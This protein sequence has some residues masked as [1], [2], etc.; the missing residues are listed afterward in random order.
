[1]KIFKWIFALIAG[2]GGILAMMLVPAG[3]KRKKIKALDKKIKAVDEEIK[4]TNKNKLHNKQIIKHLIDSEFQIF[5]HISEEV[6]NE[7]NN[8]DDDNIVIDNRLLSKT[9]H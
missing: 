8:T 3:N 4:N 6:L 2:I 7:E 5:Q 1:M 9:C